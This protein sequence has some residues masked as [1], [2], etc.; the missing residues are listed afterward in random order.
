MASGLVGADIGRKLLAHTISSQR[1][2]EIARISSQVANEKERWAAQ[3]TPILPRQRAAAENWFKEHG[4][5]ISVLRKLP[6]LEL[7]KRLNFATYNFCTPGVSSFNDAS[8]LYTKCTTTCAGFAQF[9][10][11][12]ATVVGLQTRLLNIYNIPI[13]DNHTAVEVLLSDGRWG[14]VDPTF[15]AFF[16]SNGKTGGRLLSFAEVRETLEPRQL[17]RHVVQANHAPGASMMAPVGSL[18][19]KRFEHS[20]MPIENYQAFEAVSHDKPNE[21]VVLQIN[22]AAKNGI[23]RIGNFNSDDIS[24][25]S[26]DWLNA[27]EPTI[28]DQDL[29][30]RI[31]FDTAYLSNAREDTATLLSITNIVPGE[32]YDLKV[33]IVNQYILPQLL[34]VASIGW[35]ADLHAHPIQTIPRGVSTLSMEF[36][37]RGDRAQI[38]L[39]NL[40]K[41]SLLEVYAIELSKSENVSAVSAMDSVRSET[42]F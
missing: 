12:L 5:N 15:G 33:R 9:Y 37:A 19:S 13:Q 25:L 22:L 31:S 16:T 42:S 6:V 21:L 38:Y 2:F 32:G 34:Q 27:T 24:I 29:D 1:S 28:Q 3:Y 4:Y 7:A 35:G 39:H 17:P 41:N 40:E 23:V 8:E 36:V 11:G 30:K 18:F 14:F 20:A 26:R 10:R